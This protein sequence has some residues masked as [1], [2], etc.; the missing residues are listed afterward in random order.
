MDYIK[1]DGLF[2]SLILQ[3]LMEMSVSHPH[4]IETIHKQF[5][6][7]GCNII[8]SL[9]NMRMQILYIIHQIRCKIDFYL[10]ERSRRISRFKMSNLAGLSCSEVIQQEWNGLISIRLPEYKRNWICKPVAMK[11]Y[12]RLHC[13]RLLTI[14]NYSRTCVYGLYVYVWRFIN[15]WS[16]HWRILNKE[17]AI[18]LMHNWKN[19]T[20]LW[21]FQQ[22]WQYWKMII[23]IKSYLVGAN[24]S[25]KYK[26]IILTLAS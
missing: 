8:L 18:I 5:K 1:S 21:K 22:F 23:D 12:T 14:V 10:H 25:V 11:T 9:H 20:K 17:L 24:F 19:D 6:N 16:E 7:T 26:W 4:S 3:V 13:A 2:H 15:M